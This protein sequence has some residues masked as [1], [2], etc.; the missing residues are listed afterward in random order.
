MSHYSQH[1][2]D[3]GEFEARRLEEMAE[4]CRCRAREIEVEERE[5]EEDQARQAET[6][7]RREEILDDWYKG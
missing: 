3:D 7:R 4:S 5:Y 1:S 2:E 6:E